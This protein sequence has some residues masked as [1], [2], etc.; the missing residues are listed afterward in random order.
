MPPAALQ[1]VTY[2]GQP[3]VKGKRVTGFT[4]SEE[5]AVHLTTV[6]SFLVE[7]EL[8][9]LGRDFEMLSI[10]PISQSWTVG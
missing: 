8:R 3:I 2:E 7:D 10:G 6:V 4:N 9:R 1:K 5:D